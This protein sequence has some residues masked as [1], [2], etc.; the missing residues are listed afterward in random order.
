MVSSIVAMHLR[1]R[2][3]PY[4]II[5]DISRMFHQVLVRNEDKDYLR[6]L[7]KA[8]GTDNVK[9]YRANTIQFGCIDSPM[10][11]MYILQSHCPQHLDDPKSTEDIKQAARLI[12]GSQLC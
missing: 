5:G 4:V 8:P 10:I 11:C 3:E 6:L 7:F 1:L 12:L 2:Q 9:I